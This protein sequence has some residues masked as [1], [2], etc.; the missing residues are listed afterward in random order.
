MRLLALVLIAA[1]ALWCL[2]LLN[3]WAQRKGWVSTRRPSGSVSGSA[4]LEIEAIA[5]P[6]VRHEIEAREREAVH[7]DESGEPPEPKSLG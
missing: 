1:V 5:R 6:S 4:F 3:R 2:H 7:V